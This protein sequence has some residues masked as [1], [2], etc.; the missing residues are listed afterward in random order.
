MSIVEQIKEHIN[1][2]P[3]GKVFTNASLC[4]LGKT[5]TIR[6]TLGRL[7]LAGEIE[8]LARGVFAKP[9]K[10]SGAGNSLPSP[11]EV[12]EEIAKQ[13]GETITMHGAEAARKLHLTTQVPLQL[14]LYTTGKSRHIKVRNRTVILQNISPRKLVEPGT[15]TN[16]VISA[17]WYLGKKNVSEE[18]LH[19]ISSRI[20]DQEFANVLK[21]IERMP[22]WM[23]NVFHEYQGSRSGDKSE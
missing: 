21:H 8:R 10:T 15:V 4:H 16:I 18:T 7:V 6:K 13:T 2:L 22:A 23:V 14:A 17:L 11:R 19:T 1:Q 12:I 20:G 9:K 3:P 5:D